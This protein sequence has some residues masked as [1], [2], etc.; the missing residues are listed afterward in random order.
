MTRIKIRDRENRKFLTGFRDMADFSREIGIQYPPGGPL[1]RTSERPK[2]T[3][4]NDPR[5]SE[6]SRHD[7][8]DL[9]S[10]LEL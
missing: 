6:K 10:E 7:H 4:S 2:K 5:L 1:R 9:K 8:Q 3:A